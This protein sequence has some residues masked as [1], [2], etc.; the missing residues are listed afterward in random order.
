MHRRNSIGLLLSSLGGLL[1]TLLV[2]LAIT[3]TWSEWKNLR[4]MESAVAVNA[5]A[6]SLLVAIE[7]LTLERGL[8]NTALNGEAPVAHYAHADS[9]AVRIDNGGHA[10]VVALVDMRWQ[11]TEPG[12]RAQPI[13]Q[14]FALTRQAC[15]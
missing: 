3:N 7:R 4:T 15:G 5:A 11:P 10:P 13:A 1:G 2:A 12:F 6:D 14:G 9:D 8:T